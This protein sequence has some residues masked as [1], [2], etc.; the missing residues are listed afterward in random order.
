MNFG[1]LIRKSRLHAQSKDRNYSLRKTAERVGIQPSY[2]SKI[3][4]GELPPPGEDVICKLSKE[5]NLDTD[6]MLAM[7]GKVS[8]ELLEVIRSRPELF[9]TLLRELKSAPDHAVLKLVREVRDGEW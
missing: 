5:L 6:V 9:A 8:T 2:L 1:K 4:R 3:E 7:A